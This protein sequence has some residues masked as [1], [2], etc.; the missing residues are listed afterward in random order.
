MYY[1]VPIFL[2]T[3]HQYPDNAFV[4]EAE[5]VSNEHMKNEKTNKASVKS[6][7]VQ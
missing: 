3:H 6:S 7:K 5:K 1:R 4:K 2:H